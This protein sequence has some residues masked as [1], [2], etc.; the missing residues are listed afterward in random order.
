MAYLWSKDLE[1]GNQMI[2]NQHKQLIE[3][4]NNLL[5]ACSSAKGQET[6]N[7]TMNFL[8]DYTVKHFA[9]EEKLQIQ[10]KYPDYENHKKL[11]DNFKKVVSELAVQLKNEGATISLVTKV[12]SQIGSWL[13]NHIKKEDIKIAEFIK[14]Q[15]ES[16]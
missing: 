7:K 11:H 2:D 6:L 1:I 9:D 16:K 8:V 13:R 5:E 3:A 12:N 4:L 15:K 14:K 10:Y